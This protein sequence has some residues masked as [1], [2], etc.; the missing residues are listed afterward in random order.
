[1]QTQQIFDYG[2]KASTRKRKK[3]I[4]RRNKALLA[5]LSAV[6]ILSIASVILFYD[7]IFDGGGSAS[8][9]DG[10]VSAADSDSTDAGAGGGGRAPLEDEHQDRRSSTRETVFSDD[11]DPVPLPVDKPDYAQHDHRLISGG[12]GEWARLYSEG[13][14]HTSSDD[15]ADADSILDLD[16]SLDARQLVENSQLDTPVGFFSS[17]FASR[18]AGYSNRKE[19]MYHDDGSRNW[20]Y[21]YVLAE[22]IQFLFGHHI[23]RLLNPV[24]GD[25]VD[26]QYGETEGF[27]Y[28]Q[29]RQLFTKRW[30]N[31][32]IVEGD[33]SN[34]PLFADWEGDGYSDYTDE[35]LSADGSPRWVGEI[36]D[37]D[38]ELIETNEGR[39]F[40]I[41]ATLDINFVSWIEGRG[42]VTQKAQLDIT[43]V[44][45]Y[46]RTDLYSYRTILDSAELEFI[47]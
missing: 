8:D 29:F 24:Y 32:N 27:N 38:F 30:W 45:N 6:L 35:E 37:Y 46:D 43:I 10:G 23:E 15:I 40:E 33:P 26:L 47:N 7:D 1:M 4:S 44:P 18:S 22:D 2:M 28:N 41:E 16:S 31:A 9:D 34:L 19:D 39:S 20:E 13:N 11:Y 25:W 5:V 12:L 17:H 36:E 3:P 21:S 42:S 14:A